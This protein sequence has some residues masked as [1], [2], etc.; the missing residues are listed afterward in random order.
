MVEL[1][2]RSVCQHLLLWL[3]K[4]VLEIYSKSFEQ[5]RFIFKEYP[6]IIFSFYVNAKGAVGDADTMLDGLFVKGSKAVHFC[7]T[8]VAP[9]LDTKNVFQLEATSELVWIYSYSFWSYL[10]S[11]GLIDKLFSHWCFWI[12]VMLSK[13]AYYLSLLH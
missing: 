3:T 13:N 1:S 12:I 9:Y 10:N 4:I 8:H 2:S 11:V 7:G 6:P 5:V